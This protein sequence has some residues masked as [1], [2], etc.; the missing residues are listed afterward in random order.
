[1]YIEKMVTTGKGGNG[2]LLPSLYQRGKNHGFSV[3]IG[4]NGNYVKLWK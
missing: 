1:M 4:N 3:Y 2:K